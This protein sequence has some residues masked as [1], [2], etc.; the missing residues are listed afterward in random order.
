MFVALLCNF[1]RIFVP[2]QAVAKNTPTGSFDSVLVDFSFSHDHS[3]GAAAE[4]TRATQ[5]SSLPVS[6]VVL[7]DSAK[8]HF[9]FT[10][11]LQH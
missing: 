1:W 4:S 10:L 9:F 3:A 6:L 8:V 11:P 5:F 2:I 7:S